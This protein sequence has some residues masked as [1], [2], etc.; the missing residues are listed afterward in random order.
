M[1]VSRVRVQAPSNIA[2]IK[3]MGKK[4]A[5]L[6]IPENASLSMTL[7][8]L[9]TTVEL[10][11]DS[12][13]GLG[14]DS[15]RWLNELPTQLPSL[16]PSLSFDVP[17]IGQAGIQ[18]MCRYSEALP[19]IF[20]G[21]QGQAR[22]ARSKKTFRT[23]NSFPPSSG[24]A[25]SASS[26]A[27]MTLAVA[28]AYSEDPVAFAEEF[29]ESPQLRRALAVVSRQ[30]SGSSCRSF[31]GPWV[32]WEEQSAAF[33]DSVQM[34]E[35][36][37]FVVLVE[38]QP[39]KVSSSQAHH[40]VQT[41]PLWEKR[42]QNVHQR[43]LRMEEALRQGDLPAVSHLAWG[44]A[45]EMH[46]LFHTCLE[47]FSYWTPGTIEGLHWLSS[48]LGEALPPIVTLD[49]GPNLHVIV[50]RNQQDLWRERL[51]NQFVG[52]PILEDQPGSG[53]SILSIE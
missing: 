22:W 5:S 21:S 11:I 19:Q 26:F 29:N 18:R 45:W 28:C 37:H 25:S 10:E 6:N 12:E 7:K 16:N 20:Y 53:A 49:A 51:K 36:S 8:D 52:V 13:D 46:E 34:P 30:G 17:M 50:E 32:Y 4:D 2:L 40:L 1:S 27:A 14:K 9:C 47:P 39:K 42:L 15:V 31:E 41:S 3:Y 44:E 48:F 38:A 35:L 23:A 43:T 24:I 33:M